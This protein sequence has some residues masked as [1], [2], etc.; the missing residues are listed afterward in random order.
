MCRLF[1]K[2]ASASKM[3]LNVFLVCMSRKSASQ[4]SFPINAETCK[5][6]PKSNEA[7]T[8]TSTIKRGR[9]K[10]HLGRVP[11]TTSSPPTA[12]QTTSRNPKSAPPAI[13]T[14]TTTIST[15]TN[16]VA[17]LFTAHCSQR[18]YNMLQGGR[19]QR[20]LHQ[21]KAVNNN[22]ALLM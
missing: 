15:T 7:S 2:V 12:T 4:Y 10:K 17:N 1:L 21:Q 5:N 18:R 14:T 16:S 6:P 3:T 9:L 20:S 19:S 11:L 13:T 22:Q 8:S